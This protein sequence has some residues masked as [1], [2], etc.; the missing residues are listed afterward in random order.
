MG[1]NRSAGWGRELA[2]RGIIPTVEL[3][4]GAVEVRSQV[5]ERRAIRLG[6]NADDDIRREI[7]RQKANA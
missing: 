2:D 7:E 4:D 6:A 1:R 5:W 3:D